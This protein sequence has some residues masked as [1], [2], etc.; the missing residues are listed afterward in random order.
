[1]TDVR[2]VGHVHVDVVDRRPHLLEHSSADETSRRVAN[3][4]TSRPFIFPQPV[5]L[6]EATEPL[7]G[8]RMLAAGAVGAEL[9]AEESTR[10]DRLQHDGASAVPEQDERR[11]IIPVEDLRQHVAPDDERGREAGRRASRVPARAR[12]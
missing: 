2:L 7:P 8:A 11:A 6:L 1:M 9:E 4:K 3:L 10:V 5:R 12:T